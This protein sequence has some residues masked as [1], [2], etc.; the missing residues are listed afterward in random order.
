M[1]SDIVEIPGTVRS[2]VPYSILEGSLILFQ[3]HGAAIEEIRGIAYGMSGSPLCVAGQEGEKLVGA[4]S[5][6]DI[7]TRGYLG[8]ATP[9]EYMAAMEDTFLPNPAPIALPQPVRIGG[10]TLSHV[11]VARSGR[12]ARAVAKTAATAIIA[13][14]GTVTWSDGDPVFMFGHPFFGDGAVQFYLTN[15]VVNGVWSSNI[16]PHKL[17]TPGSVRG[18]V[19]QDR[20]T[21]VAGRIGDMP[22][23]T[24]LTGS[25]EL[26]PQGT[27]GRE[28]SYRP[29]RLIDGD[30]ALLT[31]DILSAAGY[32][33]S[34]NAAAPGSA[35]TTKTIVVSGGVAPPYTVV[36]ADTWDDSYDALG[37]LNADAATMLACWSTTPTAPHRRASCRST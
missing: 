34:D 9:V 15:A 22:L 31:A 36:R 37:D 30:A 10:A 19:L 8:L 14:L 24:P 35:V 28:T 16:D 6:G 21:G 11:V 33:A 20:G 3:A 13:P 4:V 17:M 2:A 5:Y 23:E 7:F 1:G 25:V 29:R 12:E 18:S 32:N 26:Q 27:V